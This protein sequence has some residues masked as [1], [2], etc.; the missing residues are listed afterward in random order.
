MEDQD[1]QTVM[2]P[3]KQLQ[4][5]SNLHSS[6]EQ[7]H[8]TV[9]GAYKNIRAQNT[10]NQKAKHSGTIIS[11]H[12]SPTKYSH[13]NQMISTPNKV[14]RKD[15]SIGRHSTIIGSNL[16]SNNT[17]YAQSKHSALQ[18]SATKKRTN[19]TAGSSANVSSAHKTISVASSN[20]H[21]S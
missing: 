16:Q 12:I 19:L 11:S 18:N 15:L 21:Y 13:S 5:A 14:Q 10:T 20:P 2:T 9:S 3:I 6:K 7:S 4:Q 1:Q 8:Q 17:N